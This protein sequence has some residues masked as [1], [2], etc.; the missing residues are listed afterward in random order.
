[1]PP[2]CS[3]KG[4]DVEEGEFEVA[5]KVIATWDAY[6]NAD[7]SSWYV[8]PSNILYHNWKTVGNRNLF[9]AL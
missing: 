3:S 7:N 1:M 5:Y 4:E 2:T 6:G 9:F 8:S